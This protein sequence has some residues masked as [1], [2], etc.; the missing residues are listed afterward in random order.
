[1]HFN[2]GVNGLIVELA[3]PEHWVKTHLISKP[4]DGY[5]IHKLFTIPVSARYRRLSRGLK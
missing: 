4:V 3:N 2:A 5:K 1:M